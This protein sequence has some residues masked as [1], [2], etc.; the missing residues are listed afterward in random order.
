MLSLFIETSS[1]SIYQYDDPRFR[2]LEVPPHLLL[3]SLQRNVDVLC[4]LLTVSCHVLLAVVS[5]KTSEIP[6]SANW[7]LCFLK[8]ET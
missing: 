5:L 7:L 1:K 3:F 2:L 6:F 4:N 8:D